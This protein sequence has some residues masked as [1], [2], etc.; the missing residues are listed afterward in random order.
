MLVKK[1]RIVKVKKSENPKFY[2]IQNELIISFIR[3][4]KTELSCERC[5]LYSS[6]NQLWWRN[7]TIINICFPIKLR[8]A[9]AIYGY[10]PN[11]VWCI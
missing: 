5:G 2:P 8:T 11:E 10:Q 4:I 9:R 6:C 1:Y 3:E 7:N